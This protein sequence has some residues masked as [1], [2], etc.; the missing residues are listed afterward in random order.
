MHYMSVYV[1]CVPSAS[2]EYA[3]LERFLFV[4]LLYTHV[5]IGL[6][7]ILSRP[8]FFVF[9]L[10]QLPVPWSTVSKATGF[11]SQRQNMHHR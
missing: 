6:Q 4:Q 7:H 1:M 5:Y 9:I 2:E 11:I 10:Q 8:T 3:S